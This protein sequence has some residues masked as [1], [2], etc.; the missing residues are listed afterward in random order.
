MTHATEKKNTSFE[1]GAAPEGFIPLC[2]P[3]LRGN[4]WKYVKD[5]F[6]TGWVS[7]VGPYVDRFERTVAEY[8]GAAHGVAVVNGTSALQIAL[9]LAGVQPDDEVPVSTLTFIAPVNTI[10]YV[11]AWPVLI[12]AEPV[13]WQM[14]VQKLSDFLHHECV[15][16]NNELRNKHTGRRVRALMPVH[17]LGHTVDLD[18]VL[19]LGRKFNLPVIEDATECLGARYKGRRAGSI[20]DVGVFSFNGN[21]IITTGGG[22]MLVTSNAAWAAKAKYLT[23]QA[24]DDPLEYIHNE[25]GYNFRLTNVLAAFGCAQMEVLEEFIAAKRALAQ[26]YSEALKTQAGI[27]LP[28]QAAWCESIWWMYTILVDR[29]VYGEDSRAL[30]KRLSGS[31]IQSRPLWQP[32]HLSVAH[33]G[34]YAYRCEVAEQLN[35]DALSIP[36]SSSLSLAEQE[37]VLAVL[38]RS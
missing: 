15:W 28:R 29:Q 19:E 13:H 32:C 1:P 26:R 38:K 20:G 3:S 10:R 36:C 33:K 37:R 22:G 18:P 14:D 7:S 17:I 2:M 27:T 30:L 8:S 11:G 35:R 12:D 23:T 34:A 31:S 6:D 5:C 9:L 24:K 21:K 16:K 25:I 4:E